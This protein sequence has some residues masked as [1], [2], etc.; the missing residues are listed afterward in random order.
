MGRVAQAAFDCELAGAVPVVVP[1]LVAPAVTGGGLLALV[2]AVVAA[3]T[4][5]TEVLGPGGGVV[6]VIPTNDMIGIIS[7]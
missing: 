7:G 3:V 5:E 1:V 4:T 2:G 6:A